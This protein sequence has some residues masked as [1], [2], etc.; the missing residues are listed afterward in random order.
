[1]E[2]TIEGLGFRVRIYRL[3]FRVIRS[4]FRL[5]QIGGCLGFLPC[6]HD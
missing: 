4:N 1:M 3:R 5:V 6:N 2:A